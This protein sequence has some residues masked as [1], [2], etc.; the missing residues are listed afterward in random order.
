MEKEK[1]V[2]YKILSF[3]KPRNFRLLRLSITWPDNQ[4]SKKSIDP[5]LE[6]LPVIIENIKF[7]SQKTKHDNLASL[8][9]NLSNARLI[10]N[11]FWDTKIKVAFKVE[12]RFFKR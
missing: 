1:L 10:S 5:I 11:E 8:D 7:N 12:S 4:E 6:I 3:L 9:Y 2:I